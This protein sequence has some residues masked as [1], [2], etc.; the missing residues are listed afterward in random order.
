MQS[1]YTHR[2]HPI[3]CITSPPPTF[4]PP[5]KIRPKDPNMTFTEA[6]LAPILTRAGLNL[7]SDQ[8]RALLPGAAI[9]QTMIDRVNAPLP[10]EAE[11]AVTF[12][13]EQP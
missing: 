13:V 12:K 2:R 10:R 8:V 7:T 6:T 4:H 9:I 5:N 11:L 3:R 1:P